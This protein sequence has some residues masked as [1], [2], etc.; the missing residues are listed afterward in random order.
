MNDNYSILT[1]ELKKDIAKDARDMKLKGT[2][3]VDHFY[4]KYVEPNRIASP[5]TYEFSKYSDRHYANQQSNDNLINWMATHRYEL[6]AD[7]TLG[8]NGIRR[9]SIVSEAMGAMKE[10][11]ERGMAT[12][13]GQDL[14]NQNVMLRSAMMDNRPDMF[15]IIQRQGA[16]LWARDKKG[17][18]SP[19]HQLNDIVKH[20]PER[21]ITELKYNGPE[22]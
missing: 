16:A 11:R 21:E 13:N 18:M 12:F 1:N 10:A 19:V 8:D 20:L 4:A 2:E 3:L 15:E 14:L 6:I 17:Q 9:P 7:K 5:D 22:R